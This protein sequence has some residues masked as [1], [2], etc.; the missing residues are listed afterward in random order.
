MTRKS[1]VVW[2]CLGLS[3]TWLIASMPAEMAIIARAGVHFFEQLLPLALG[4]AGLLIVGYLIWLMG[5][6]VER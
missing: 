3:W 6:A 2:L 5:Q 1:L 4:S